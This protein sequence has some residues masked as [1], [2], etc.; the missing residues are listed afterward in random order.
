MGRIN[1]VLLGRPIYRLLIRVV[2]VHVLFLEQLQMLFY[3]VSAF[4]VHLVMFVC[5]Y[6]GRNSGDWL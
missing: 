3:T 2:I 6:N 4:A 1:T 5:N